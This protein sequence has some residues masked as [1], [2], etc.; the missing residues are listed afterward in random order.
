MPRGTIRKAMSGFYYVK[1][2]EGT[3]QCR[4]RGLFRKQNI[5]PLVG[6]N[7]EFEADNQTEGVITSVA[8]RENELARP[9]IANVD[10]AILVSSVKEPDFHTK[11]LDRFLVVIES[12]F[13][14][15][16]ICFTKMDLI[17]EENQEEI[18][19]YIED[20][21]KIGYTCVQTSSEIDEGL[22]ELLP[23]VKGKTSVVA[24]QSGV[25]KSSLLNALQPNLELKTDDIS[26]A[27]G[28]GKHTTRHVEL[29]EI[30]DG[31][32]ADT[33]GFSSLDFQEIEKETLPHC[34][35]EFVER[36]SQCKFRG[37]SHQNEPKCAVKA[38]VENGEIPAYR[39]EHYKEFY[40]EIVDR[41][42]R[43]PSS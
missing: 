10:Q 14:L 37:C 17:S 4:G 29:L 13:I 26:A 28:R 3:F 36:A 27:L 38:A 32:I 42:P 11:L 21:Q 41:K 18:Q 40:Q 33:P 8:E 5:T 30:G 22:E 16:I 12:K 39:Y 25:G 6:D 43:Y 2:D 24:G 9:P 35:P 19:K 15:P 23:Y 20:Y 34:F 31:L 1:S 7:V